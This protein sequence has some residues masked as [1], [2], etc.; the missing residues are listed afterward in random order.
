MARTLLDDLFL[1]VALGGLLL[2]L[3]K[4]DAGGGGLIISASGELGGFDQ[5]MLDILVLSQA[6]TSRLYEI[7]WSLTHRDWVRVGDT[8]LREIAPQQTERYAL[9]ELTP[10]FNPTTDT[11]AVSLTLFSR[12]ISGGSPREEDHREFVLGGVIT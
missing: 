8:L 3:P 9:I 11:I 12:A 7:A 1:L 6:S 10:T 4:R 5:V 2:L